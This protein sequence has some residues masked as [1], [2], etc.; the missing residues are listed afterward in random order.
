VTCAPAFALA[1]AH[2]AAVA[3]AI[4][5]VAILVMDDITANNVTLYLF[6]NIQ[7]MCKTRRS[8]ATKNAFGKQ[9]VLQY[10]PLF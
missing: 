5:I 8:I 4:M 2:A 7:R 6:E 3:A 9:W 1:P 10:S